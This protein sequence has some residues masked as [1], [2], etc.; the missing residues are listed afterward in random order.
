MKTYRYSFVLIVAVIITLTSA[1]QN[2]ELE[3]REH[4]RLQTL[5]TSNISAE[6]ATFNGEVLLSGRENI[7]EWG[8]VWNEGDN[9]P[10]LENSNKKIHQQPFA[11]GKFADFISTT[12]KSNTIYSV[13]AFAKT[14]S[15]VVYGD[16][17]KF[18]SKGSGAADILS[19]V[20]DTGSWGD[21]I[22]IKGSAF[23]YRVVENKV[24]LGNLEAE[25][26][27]STDSTI[28]FKVPEQKNSQERVKVQVNIANQAALSKDHFTYL[29][30]S[31][32]DVSPAEA[33]Y[34]DIIT[35][36]G[37]N[38]KHLHTTVF[39]NDIPANISS[40]SRSEIQVAV[41]PSIRYQENKIIVKSAGYEIEWSGRFRLHQPTLTQFSPAK[42][43]EY[44]ELI[45]ISGTYFNPEKQYNKV[46]IGEQLADIIENSTEKLVV[47][48]PRALFPNL[49]I[50]VL[51]SATIRV[52]TGP[53]SLGFA[54]KL[55]IDWR[56]RWTKKKDFPGAGRYGAIAFAVGDK[57]YAGTGYQITGINAGNYLKDFWEYNP[58]IDQWT[59]LTDV[60][61]DARARAT[62]FALEGYGYAGLGT[63]KWYGY[64]NED[65][66][67]TPNK[68][69]YRFNPS[70]RSWTKLNDFGGEERHSAA[71]FVLNNQAY[72]GTGYAGLEWP[73]H[74]RKSD[75][76]R[77]YAAQDNWV[78]VADFPYQ[79]TT[80]VGYTFN[81]SA[82]LYDT[83]PFLNNGEKLWTYNDG[84]NHW[85]PLNG[86]VISF[87]DLF[88]FEIGGKAY[89]GKG[90]EYFGGKYRLWE[91][92]PAI[93]TWKAFDLMVGTD[94]VS[95]SAQSGVE[96][97]S[98]FVVNDKAYIFFGTQNMNGEETNS[99]EV[100]E[101]DPS[102]PAFE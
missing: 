77:Y 5:E 34:N 50:T 43:T 31:I 67:F 98:A 8:F 100:W 52:E 19:I 94:P 84:S 91:Y 45:T 96:K 33:T 40:I 56:S 95:N 82:Y 24:R 47:R 55:E 57:G 26:L 10:T 2:E 44:N 32:A 54:Q 37:A 22:T 71:A 85:S 7:Q 42:A 63:N 35:I 39:F 76:W 51:T 87:T 97:S 15:Y 6:G 68:D 59:R 27:A 79:S 86:P 102:K 30:P 74:K 90:S 73:Y 93:T 48:L 101:F 36:K 20:P 64:N 4:P 9:L 75:F 17:I 99:K 83:S 29:P 12:L 11:K 69:F 49:N 62:A 18:L 53:F 16:Q 38:F 70:S 14:Q 65:E 46:F 25:V 92:D 23:S 58:A 66:K 21:T 61:G 72:V 80:A 60:P 88:A 81:Q 28:V 3:T 41:P 89:L 1:C 13:R 78:R